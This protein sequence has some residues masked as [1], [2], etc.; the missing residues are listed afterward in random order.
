[1]CV[2]ALHIHVHLRACMYVYFLYKRCNLFN[3]MS[4]KRIANILYVICDTICDM[5]CVIRDRGHVTCGMTPGMTHDTT[6][7]ATAAMALYGI[8]YIMIS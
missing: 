2:H 3:T 4:Y 5:R 8:L 6:S 7:A 1:M